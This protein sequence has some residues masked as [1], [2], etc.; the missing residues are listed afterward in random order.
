MAQT[1]FG[2]WD[3]VIMVAT[4][5]ASIVIGLYFR[6]SGGKQKTNDEY[7]LADRNMSIFPV[8]VSLM[9]SF[10]SAITLLGLS[11][12]N[13]YF[14]MQFAVINIAYGIATPVASRLYLPVFFGLQKTSTYEYLELRFGPQI[15]MLASLTYTLQMVLYNGIVLYAPA[16]VLESVTGLDRLISILVVGLV[17][18]F[19]SSLGG[20][21]AVLFT[22]LLQS[23]LMFGAVFSVVIFASVQL[24]GFEQI[25]IKARDGGRLDFSNFSVD[26]TERHTWWS[27]II[28]GCITYLSLYAVNHT[29]VQRLLT[30]STL[31]RS[32]QCL[33]WSWPVL[34]VLSIVTCISGLSMYAVY[35]DCDPLASKRITGADQLMPFYVVDAMKSMPGLAGLFVAGIFSA[36]LSTISASC[37]A[38]AAVT[39]TDYVGRW[40]RINPSYVPWLTKLAACGFGL[41]FLALAFIAE[42]LGGVLQ[43]SL[44]IFGAVGGPLLGIFTLGMFT[45]YANERGVSVALLTGMA[46]TLWISF[47]GP[48]PLPVK[49]PVSVKGCPGNVTLSVLSTPPPSDYFY[50]YRVSYMWTSPIGFIWVLVVGSIV[51]LAWKQQHPWQKVGL[52]HPDPA[53]FT[54]PLASRLRAKYDK[55]SSVHCEL[56]KQNGQE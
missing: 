27:L 39:L 17:C 34:S 37:N 5:L 19:Y 11:A 6:F 48:R 28:G 18:T 20:M 16:I 41:V 8:A 53:L 47:G 45:T 24:G 42:H 52:A 29:Q 49:L 12:E 38:L 23:F 40:C 31:D 51:S 2:V 25:F 55:K 30:V 7:L 44:T 15:R 3:Y 22:D 36:S 9:A 10:M 13:Y 54:P 46:V 33:W 14:G 50:M 35:K 56:L 32:Q 1:I 43:A 4:M 26:P 21:K